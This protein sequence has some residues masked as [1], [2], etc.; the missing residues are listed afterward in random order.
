MRTCRIAHYIL[1]IISVLDGQPL[2]RTPI[3]GSDDEQFIAEGL[4]GLLAH[5]QIR[6]PHRRLFAMQRKI[7]TIT[8]LSL[9]SVQGPS[10]TSFSPQCS[11][12]RQGARLR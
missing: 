9:L 11:S 5:P 8:N 12:R 3:T 6:V 10:P 2:T 1:A 7:W 4:P